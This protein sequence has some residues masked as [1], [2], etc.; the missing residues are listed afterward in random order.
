M[1][2]R[3]TLTLAVLALSLLVAGFAMSMWFIPLGGD[4][5]E[6]YRPGSS[7]HLDSQEAL[8]S[9]GPILLAA[10][11]SGELAKPHA[12]TP[13]PFQQRPGLEIITG[14]SSQSSGQPAGPPWTSWW[15]RIFGPPRADGPI[16]PGYHKTEEAAGRGGVEEP[17]PNPAANEQENGDNSGYSPEH[18]IDLGD[19][20]L[21]QG[22][23]K[24][25]VPA[26]LALISPRTFLVY[27]SVPHN[28]LSGLP[29]T[30]IHTHFSRDSSG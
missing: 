2:T 7:A 14:G 25:W 29:W 6:E 20:E 5:V 27:T 18:L 15:H 4:Y 11:Y 12:G 22:P 30:Q 24:Q 19:S 17:T 1:S 26:V 3:R 21:P 9:S 23:K 10:E 28:G 13:V 8:N 16:S